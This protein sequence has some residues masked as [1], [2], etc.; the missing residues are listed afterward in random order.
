MK[1]M[2]GLSQKT[3]YLLSFSAFR[4]DLRLLTGQKTS[5]GSNPALLRLFSS[6]SPHSAAHH[7]IR[8][9]GIIGRL[10]DSFSIQEVS[11]RRCWHA[12]ACRASPLPPSRLVS[13]KPNEELCPRPAVCSWI[14]IR[15][16]RIPLIE[17]V[18]ENEIHV[19]GTVAKRENQNLLSDPGGNLL[20]RGEDFADTVRS[21][22]EDDGVKACGR[23]LGRR[24]I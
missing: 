15:L 3:F 5:H 2:I 17:W 14:A 6:F 7:V 12:M 16:L 10:L 11:L 24:G 21:C 4:T 1:S 22:V 19:N 9:A 8:T 13:I 18:F 23:G 20:N